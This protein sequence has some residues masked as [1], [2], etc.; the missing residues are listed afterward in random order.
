[1]K[2]FA[3]MAMLTALTVSPG[4]AVAASA[5]TNSY[6]S[7]SYSTAQQVRAAEHI[8]FQGQ[9]ALTDVQLAR[10][11]LFQ[12][13]PEKALILTNHASSLLTDDSLDW[14]KFFHPGKKTTLK[15][16]NYVAINAVMGVSEDYISSPEKEDSIK[17]ANEKLQKGDK[18]GAVNELRLAGIG[19]TQNVYLM[20]LKQTRHAVSEALRLLGEHKYY[21]ANLVLKGA[22]DGVITEST[23]LFAD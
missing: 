4:L 5:D 14:S 17:R 15:D 2:N 13:Q 12:G 1:M 20:P 18:K 9:N 6:H 22:E 11:A 10:V 23:T 16:D 8:A 19:V 3:M 7:T 21:E